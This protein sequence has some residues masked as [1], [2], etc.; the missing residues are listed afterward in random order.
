MVP[1]M[2]CAGGSEVAHGLR[3]LGSALR[4]RATGWRSRPVGRVQCSGAPASVVAEWRL[5]YR[6][7]PR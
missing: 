2:Q 3:L 5:H 7:T 1:Q 6:A 4:P